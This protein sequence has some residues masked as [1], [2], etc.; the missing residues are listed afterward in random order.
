MI[1]AADGVEHS[2]YA[3]LSGWVVE[4]NSELLANPDLARRQPE[5]SGWL[6]RLAPQNLDREIANLAPG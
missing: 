5:H 1:R 4:I 2:L 6:L 3:P